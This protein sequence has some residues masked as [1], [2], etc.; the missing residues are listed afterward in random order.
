MMLSV[1][2]GITTLTT[3][4]AIGKG[5]Q[6]QIVKGIKSFG[7]NSIMVAAGGG[8]GFGPPDS[9]TTTLTLDDAK[10]IQESIKN[11]KYVAPFTTSFGNTFVYGNNNLVGIVVGVTPIWS[12]AWTWPIE[13][14]EFISEEDNASLSKNCVIGKTVVDELFAGQNPIGETIRIND[15]TFKVIG[16]LSK[17][18]TSPHGMDLDK[19][20][21]VPIS[22]AMK[23]LSNVTY[24]GNIRVY[25]EEPSTTRLF[26]SDPSGLSSITE[27]ITA[28]LRERHHITPPNEDDFRITNS[29]SVS[30]TVD[31]VTGT[32]TKFLGLLSLIILVVG[33]V[34]IANIMFI[35]V[36]ERKKEIGI[37]RAFGARGKDILGQ[38]LI[39][40]IVTTVIGGVIGLTL[41]FFIA[42]GI[43]V[44]YG[45]PA[46]ISWEPVLLAFVFSV[47]VGVGAG[48][49]PAR[50]AAIMDP[51]MAIR[52]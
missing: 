6:Q 13:Q 2:I 27:S 29:I 31:N 47:L 16:V 49:Q 4:V 23:K 46:I 32:M 11:I 51:V 17:R 25:A 48:I 45:L 40:T 44:L 12:E 9:T 39:E 33:G 50:K 10:A 22:T 1:V 28:L 21:V 15:T 14:G 5:A 36:N 3:I 38:F 19:R 7:P 34:V 43:S 42:K 18:G 26:A 41:G 35:S 30:E 20:V 37:R 52:G 24:I 8:A